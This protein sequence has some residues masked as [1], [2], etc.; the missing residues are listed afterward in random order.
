MEATLDACRELYNAALQER[1]DCYRWTHR[2][3]GYLAQAE[4]LPEIKVLRP[5]LTSIHSQ[6]LQDVLRRM[7]KAFD[8]FFRRVKAGE[9]P[10]YPRFKGKDRYDSFTY[11][12][13]GWKIEGDKLTLSK[14]GSMRIR[15]SRPIEGVVKTVTIKREVR[16]W[17]AIFSCETE[18][19]P[20]PV[21]G[22][23]VGLDLG[24]EYF[25]ATDD[26]EVVEPPKYL[27]QSEEELA[28]AQRDLAIRKPRARSRPFIAR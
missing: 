6:V 3:I 22:N 19:Q 27:R 16:K 28:E 12:Q 25:I 11:P 15:L 18:T 1:R 24:L 26:G 7:M 17:Y 8:N 2:G 13:S 10:G 5:E 4:Q 9:K 21:T 20:L 14:I 23:A